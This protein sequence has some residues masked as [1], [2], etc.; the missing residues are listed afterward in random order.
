MVTSTSWTRRLPGVE[1]RYGRVGRPLRGCYAA[2][3]VAFLYFL[4]GPALS[5][6]LGAV[7]ILAWRA[8]PARRKEAPNKTPLLRSHS[9]VLAVFLGAL[10]GWLIASD[11][12]RAENALASTCASVGRCHVDSTLRWEGLPAID[13][14]VKQRR[15]FMHA[16]HA[17][18]EC[19]ASLACV[20]SG[21]CALRDGGCV[22]NAREDCLLTI[23]CTRYGSCSP[24]DG[25][26]AI[27][28]DADCAGSEACTLRGLCATEGGACVAITDDD[29]AR[30]SGCGERGE[31]VALAGACVKPA[32][33][34]TP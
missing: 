33:E 26:C 9:F 7:I 14:I 29:C 18:N 28:V 10:P 17:E 20:H 32:A 30:S 11:Y 31:C 22:A 2:A 4:I 15:F 21:E 6:I 12:K 24:V 27:Q 8:T 1:Q 23:G 5:A 25:K 34:L 13:R 3:R 19:R 16:A